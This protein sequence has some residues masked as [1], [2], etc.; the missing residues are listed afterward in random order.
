MRFWAKK[1]IW[2]LLSLTVIAVV[3]ALIVAN[4]LHRKSDREAL[5]NAYREL[6]GDQ[7]QATFKGRLDMARLLPLYESLDTSGCPQNFR[8]AWFDYT[9][10]LESAQRHSREAL[11]AFGAFLAT[12]GLASA[13]M[14]GSALKSTDAAMKDDP[15]LAVRAV[16]RIFLQYDIGP[17]DLQ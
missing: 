11:F 6:K 5:V 4:G 9:T 13:A 3:A 1:K 2:N 12:D 17:N 8:E 16:Q 10:S 7:K 15:S 14:A